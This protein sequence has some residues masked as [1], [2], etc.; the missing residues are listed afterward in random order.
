MPV[1]FRIA[2][3]WVDIRAE[4][5]GLRQ[6]IKD[7]VEKAARDQDVKI[8]L[9]IDSKGLRKEVQDALKEA[10]KGE[11]PT[12]ALG[13]STKGLRREVTDALK[14]ATDK[15]K[16]SVKLAISSVGLRGEV[17]RA[18]TD[19]TKGQKPTVKLGISAVGLRG[20][21]QRALSEATAGQ[22][23]T[24]TINTRVDTDG[25]QRALADS[26]PTITPNIDV[27]GMRQRML[28]ALRGIDINE[29]VTINPDINGA[30]LRAQIQAQVS[31]LRNRFTVPVTP[32]VNTT[33][34]AARMMAAARTVSGAASGIPITFNPNINT[35]MLRAQAGQAAASIRQNLT[36]HG[37][38]NTAMTR[39]SLMASLAAAQAGLHIN[40]PVRIDSNQF[41]ML[42]NQIG[43]IEQGFRAI[44]GPTGR[45]AHILAGLAVV[46]GP[47][48][49]LADNAIRTT[50]ASMGALVPMLTSLITLGSAFK[51]GFEH[52]GRVISGIFEGSATSVKTLEDNLDR[53]SPQARR[54]ADELR[55]LQPAFTQLRLD[56]QDQLFKNLDITLDDFV[57]TTLPVLRRGI[58]GGAQVLHDM[59]T[60]V[61]DVMDH[62]SRMGTLDAMFG[63]IK[64]AM[65]PI[66]GI[67]GQ[68]TNALIKMSIAAS[69]LLT[70]MTTS[71]GGWA[72]KMTQKLN[73][74]FDNGRLQMSISKAGTTIVNFFRR[75]ANNPEFKTFL[76]RMQTNGP[77]I[78][79]VFAHIS[80]ALLKLL[81]ALTPIAGLFINLADM[82]ARFVNALPPV[83]LDAL[84]LKFII[85]KA[86]LGFVSLLK[87]AAVAMVAFRLSIAALSGN[88]VRL[89]QLLSTALTGVGM[90]APGISRAAAALGIFI[91]GAMLIG[92]TMLLFRTLGWAMD[93]VFDTHQSVNV[94][95][96]STAL[97]DFNKNGTLSGEAARDFG[98]SW[99]QQVDGLD[100]QFG[101]LQKAIQQIA[102][103]NAW[104]DF[105]HGFQS[106][107]QWLI[108]GKTNLE[109]YKDTVNGVDKA[110]EGLQKGGNSKEAAAIFTKLSAEANKAGTSTAKF[111]SL[112]PKYTQALKDSKV[113]QE[114][115]A[116]TMGIYG[117][118]A[119]KVQVDLDNQRQ[120]ADGLK[121]SI[122]A[123]NDAH[124]QAA[125]DQIA[126]ET[127]IDDATT[128]I[129][130][131]MKAMKDSSMGLAVNT[132]EGRA[133][134]QALLQLAQSTSAYAVSKLQ[135]TGSYSKA[136]AIY[137]HGREQFIKLAEA[138]GQTNAQAQK[139]ADTWLKMPDRTLAFKGDITDIER[140]TKDAQA[141]VDSLKQKRAT[142]VGADKKPYD[143][144]IKAA[145]DELDA[146]KQ[147]HKVSVEATKTSF[148]Q[149]IRNAQSAVDALK[150]KRKVAVGA[151]KTKL[152]AAIIA[153]QA[154]VSSLQQK[155]A[156]VIRVADLVSRGVASAQ[157]L[158]D[159][160]HGKTVTVTVMING[161]KTGVDPDKYY[162][163]GPHRF[164]G[165]IKRASGGVV[166]SYPGGGHASG[167]GGPTSDMIHA[168]ISNG[169]F[170][171]RSA[172]V[173]KYGRNFMEMVN[174]GMFPK[175]AAGGPV[176]SASASSISGGISGAP[177]VKSSTTTGTFTVTDATGKPVASAVA[178]FKILGDALTKTYTDMQAKTQ[179]FG[180]QF[181]Q[182]SV[183][184]YNAV[185]TATRNFS[186]QQVNSLSGASTQSQNVWNGWKSGMT[187]RT[188]STYNALQTKAAGFQKSNTSS[189]SSASTSAQ[190]IWTSWKSGM[191][192]RTASTYKNLNNATS[193]FQK[194][195][196]SKI[197]QAR[198]G[199]GS[200][201]GG[202]SPKFKPPVSYLVHTV[203]NS[204]IVG[205]MNA[206]MSKLGGG[207][208]IGGISVAG[209][210]SGGPIYGSGTKTSDS[211]P[212]RLSHG[213]YVIQAKAV[214]KFGVGFLNSINQG[215]MP[216][217]GAGFKPGFAT[218]GLVNIRMAPGFATGGAVPSADTL[219]NILGDG[220]DAGAKKM[221]NYIM[222]N[223]VL[224]LIDSGSGG[225]AMK[226]VQKAGV[227]H[228]Q[229]NVEKF[230]KENFGGAGSASAGLRWAKT[231]Y[232]KPYQWGGNGNP[233]WDC[234]GFMSAIESVIRG[235]KPHR[236]WA[237][238][239]FSG[240]TAPSGWKL[241]ATAPF[242]IG[243]TNAGVGHTA[244]TI[245]K[246]NVESSG[247]GAGVHGGASAR[248]WNNPM[249]PSHYGYVG[250]NAT[251]KAFGGY[252]S[253]PGGPTADA[254][255]AMLSNGEFVMRA[256]AVK[257]LGTGY[258]SALNN[259]N[260]R[261]F[262]S[263]G[264]T[265]YKI[266]SGD[267]LSGIA[268]KFHTTVSALMSLNKSI[269]DSN[270]ITA[271]QTI[272]IK[273]ALTSVA[274][275]A[276]KVAA[277][278]AA[279]KGDIQ[280]AGAKT[281]LQNLSTLR[282]A[283]SIA[284]TY[285]AKYKNEAMSAFGASTSLDDLVS[286]LTT[287]RSA[288][289]DAFQGKTQETLAA[290]FTATA[291]KLIPLQQK[292]DTVTAS[293]AT[294]QTALD[295]VTGK[296]DSL[297]D[298]VSGAITDY[299]KITKIGTYGT[300]PTVLLNQLQTD[301]GKATQFTDMLNQLKAK[302]ISGD[303][304]GQVADA[305]LSGG[306]MATA[307]TLLQMTPE[308]IKQMNALQK[309]L[310]DQATAAGTSA[311]NSMYGA[312]VSAAQG[313]VDGLTS[314]QAAIT[315]Q[316]TAIADAMVTA[317]R[318]AL[319]IKSPSRKMM[320]VA[321][322]TADG[323]ENQLV[324]RIPGIAAVMGNLVT[325]PTPIV[326][327]ISAPSAGAGTIANGSQS[328]GVN[329]EQLNVN[330]S[331]EGMNLATPADRRALAKTIVK[332]MKEEIRLDDKKRK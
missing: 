330:V 70:R 317:I 125:G 283:Q 71:F 80:E 160:M 108:G 198:D 180:T 117:D 147:K 21:V 262:A 194:Q 239:S 88:N 90:S 9:K 192:T 303:L 272:V 187:S 43:S 203:I 293:L 50:G 273:K 116:L 252:I 41:L 140:K 222:D 204:G 269:K 99:S 232:G 39:A 53:L 245:G 290:K 65:Q 135:E 325:V 19:A 212:A 318:Q 28:A 235:E 300:S 227:G 121:Q 301:V 134:R 131:S 115:A 105:F 169:E 230:V 281:S 309:Q 311:A 133:N 326:P 38:L 200:A 294:A 177:T 266:Q 68:F 3:A 213:E 217:D 168:L 298:S 73:T 76:D 25:L 58:A 154:K 279:P 137:D 233:S 87:N 289:Y 223:Y 142:A 240:A 265:S 308:Q 101:G 150:Q 276:S 118:A 158:I 312:G 75:I 246:E 207:K 195:S 228:V 183:I 313:L 162:S 141:K 215:A 196:V 35:L 4:D 208:N 86:T 31:A 18:L 92:G 277:V 14:A 124:R 51:I 247:G 286:S 319:G 321:D 182:K 114:V 106:G 296:F 285:G 167:P 48:F 112:L 85:F 10:T 122:E 46:I 291:N 156:T 172:A 241:N 267:T 237:T 27:R 257:K 297:R 175:F 264:A 314:Q 32:T 218:G 15:Q 250:P 327:T 152:D 132:A 280:D 206:I 270:K 251:K 45:Y 211:I 274:A 171:V 295:D 11:K 179:L 201:W 214:D 79:E 123:L 282:E 253:G 93:K 225:S 8:P 95:K 40:I 54:F 26:H 190:T 110:L 310:T 165:L 155:K 174:R 62:A 181:A 129:K 55:G 146:L 72:D 78:A 260:L 275:T 109:K 148:D 29:N 306:G 249:F 138:A 161:K 284:N 111:K 302:G 64:T 328:Y 5:K 220:G 157:A 304:I 259:G 63:G 292:L 107:T 103:S 199:M 236:R 16:P 159:A 305:G 278:A 173:K 119:V 234:S 258:L 120:A 84:I 185:G 59:A 82:A 263:G 255:P 104:D 128:V 74:A 254:I 219:N 176:G 13:I 287:A 188:T 261:G 248:G 323:L 49:A 243:V 30:L 98:A 44:E 271:G 163:Q 91:R 2:S 100:K 184:T 1:G 205:S 89:I 113:A 170:V 57:T 316:M 307:Q 186:T 331:G 210:A 299:G 329:I 197:G 47:A 149:D 238:G 20:E 143:S 81:N 6:Q 244:G 37:S 22:G 164:G 193:S 12:V 229:A 216:H 332:E 191:E 17:Q 231:Q 139:L 189:T 145:Q 226:A 288:I 36:F 56:V 83:F 34:F 67:P 315:A 166:Q 256:A 69:P 126:M 66:V 322:M 52:M 202:L 130:G 209:F 42:R 144:Q 178:N 97:R 24:V 151:D 221:T 242:R 224:P 77:H 61:V 324:A 153:A 320:A 268:A 102:H 23:G 33:T 136:S 60:G 7:A 94:D 96:L 127:A